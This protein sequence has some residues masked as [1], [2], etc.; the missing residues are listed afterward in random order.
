MKQPLAYRMRPS[1]LDEILGQKKLVGK[2]GI[3]R[4]CVENGMI[5]SSFNNDISNCLYTLC[6]FGLWP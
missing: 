3:L 6:T 2:D 5:F 4:K 1:S